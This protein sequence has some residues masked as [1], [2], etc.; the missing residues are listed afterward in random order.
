MNSIAISLRYAK[1]VFLLAKEKNILDAV[2]KDFIFI[3]EVIKPVKEYNDMI[4]NPT[5][6]IEQKKNLL[7]K[8][9]K[10]HINSLSLDF[11]CF[12][13]DK[14]REIYIFDIIRNFK[15]LY[16]EDANIKEVVVTTPFPINSNAEEKISGIVNSRFN[17]TA[18][19]KNNIDNS[20]LGGI[21]VKIDNLLLDMSVRSQLEEIR[22]ALKSEVYKIAL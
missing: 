6:K 3:H 15:K 13:V 17:A 12:I 20:M 5:I 16:R 22:K 21:K 8:V 10:N 4:S 11:L 1:A 14:N 19:I 7:E 18:E 9:F 2:Y